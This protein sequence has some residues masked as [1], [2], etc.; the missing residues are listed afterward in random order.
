MKAAEPR[1]ESA[2]PPLVCIIKVCVYSGRQFW[3]FRVLSIAI[4]AVQMQYLPFESVIFAPLCWQT[5]S[6]NMV[7]HKRYT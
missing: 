6:W 5:I 2:V 4:Q 7:D 1:W 3:G